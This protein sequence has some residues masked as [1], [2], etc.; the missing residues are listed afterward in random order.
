MNWNDLKRILIGVGIVIL[1]IFGAVVLIKLF[2]AL[3]QA[4]WN[5]PLAL[6]GF[7]FDFLNI[8]LNI[9]GV[10]LPP[11]VTILATLFLIRVILGVSEAIFEKLTEISNQISTPKKVNVVPTLIA[12]ITALFVTAVKENTIP[13]DIKVLLVLVLGVI[14]TILTLTTSQQKK[15]KTFGFIV[16]GICIIS[17][18]LFLGFRFDIFVPGQ[19]QILTKSVQEW[20]NKLTTGQYISMSV[21]TTFLVLMI[22]TAF[23]YREK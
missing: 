14:S 7:V 10:V 13:G 15:P 2:V 5:A 23:Y 19:I 18:L 4:I 22:I 8:I 6:A 21:F 3:V 20:F 9:L 12:G 17:V 11:L 16:L 1:I